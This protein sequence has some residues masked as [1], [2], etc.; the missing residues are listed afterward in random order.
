MLGAFGYVVL[1]SAER[2]QLFDRYV[3]SGFD[4]P[5]FAEP[6]SEFKYTRSVPLICLVSAVRGSISHVARGRPGSRAG[7]RMRRL[8]LEQIHTLDNPISKRRLLA[9]LPSRFRQH[10]RTRLINGG[11][12]P[13]ASMSALADVMLEI[14]PDVGDIF[15]SFSRTRE[16]RIA[17]LSDASRRSLAF[18]K[19]AV[20]T[21]LGLAGI[22]R[23]SIGEW[24][25]VS[26]EPPESFLDGLI[27][28]R[29]RED[30]MVVNDFVNI[31]GFRLIRSLPYSAALFESDRVRLTVL[32]ANRQPLEE[33][34]GTDLVYYNE[35]YKSFVMVQYKAMSDSDSSDG[36]RL[37]DE[38][39]AKEIR[40][41]DN[42]VSEIQKIASPRTPQQ[43]RFLDNPFFIKLC[44]RIIFNPNDSQMVRGMYF[45]LDLWKRLED[46]PNIRGERG[47]KI[48]TYETA[49][50]YFDNTEFISLVA[51]AWIGT[52][53]SQ[54]VRL[55]E[56][57]RGILEGGKAVVFA[58]K[59]QAPN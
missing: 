56:V 28:A 31:P 11:L 17:N 52:T 2:R 5:W 34:N 43:F 42:W 37:P 47:G 57:V 23:K 50:R 12:I 58:A 1:L 53:S 27:E 45:P 32:L 21:A 20:T 39:L 18:Q 19:A 8:N 51:K 33:Q 38:G 46:D 6:V 4:E 29:V 14:A 30:P 59:S 24:T 49:G 36:F 15:R 40:R 35:T 9:R 7:T 44:P 16:Q 10:V 54:S 13:Q 22:D 55:E 3:D 26:D 25:P 41:M 48:V